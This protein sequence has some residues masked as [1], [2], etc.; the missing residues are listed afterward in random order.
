MDLIKKRYVAFM[1]LLTMGA[2]VLQADPSWSGCGAPCDDAQDYCCEPPCCAQS[3]G[4]FFVGA[5]L[6]YWTPRTQGLELNF[7][8]SS[9]VQTTVG[10]DL[11]II[12]MEELDVD[13]K[14]KWNAGYRIAAGYQFDCSDFEIDAFWTH[15][16]STGHR[17]K[18][19]DIVFDPANSGKYRIKLDQFD[20]VLAYNVS[21]APCLTLKPFFGVRGTRIRQSV[22]AQVTTD[23]L[24]APDTLATSTRI[25][26][27]DQRFTGIG[28]VFGF[29]GDWNI[30]KG[31]GIYGTA[32]GSVLY[33]FDKIRFEDSQTFSPP[34]SQIVAT[35][36]KKNTHRYNCNID[37]AVGLRWQTC[38][39]DSFQLIM[40]LG[41]EHHQYFDTSYLGVS[42]D[43]ICF[44]GGIFSI[45]I[46]L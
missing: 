16:Q 21:L 27:D 44:D 17:S 30:G 8:R 41:F 14:F 31:F 4:R 32:A 19:L 24:I 28:P 26:D 1:V 23:I 45:D 29:Q 15:F 6:L 38:L 18:S 22:R 13:P 33:G 34:I 36:D 25:W 9:I 11:E 20:V 5:D 43:D 7:G 46:A 42:R 2:G 10:D 35:D 37:V 39:M 3:K 12:A 40:K